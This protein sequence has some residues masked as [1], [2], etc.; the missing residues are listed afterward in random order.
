M[1]PKC[2]VCSSIKLRPYSYENTHQLT[3]GPEFTVRAAVLQCEDCGEILDMDRKVEKNFAIE[4]KRAIKSSISEMANQLKTFGLNDSYVERAFELPQRTINRWKGVGESSASAVA[5]MRTLITFPFIADV[6]SARFDPLQ[7][8]KSLFRYAVQQFSQ[9]MRAIGMEMDAVSWDQ[10][11]L[12]QIQL[13]ANFQLAPSTTKYEVSNIPATSGT[14]A[15]T[16]TIYPFLS[17]GT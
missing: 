4:K 1:T 14:A 5:L 12:N 17:T 2:E 3:L 11:Q 16:A 13:T 6:A 15:E 7:A 9:E 10:S 8:K